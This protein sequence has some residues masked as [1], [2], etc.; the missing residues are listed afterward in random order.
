[1][2]SCTHREAEYVAA[3]WMRYLGATSCRVTQASRDGGMDIVSDTHVA[4]VKH[5]QSPVGVSFVR[6]IYGTATST[7]KMAVFFSLSEYTKEAKEFAN[8]NNIALF[9]YDPLK[10]TL[11]PKSQS[12]LEASQHGLNGGTK[13]NGANT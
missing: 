4:E 6:Q 12:A 8:A 11:A 10:A 13:F 7:S 3:Q 9:R 5:H 2:R 1:M